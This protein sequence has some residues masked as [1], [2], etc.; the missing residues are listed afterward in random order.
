MNLDERQ[1]R[2]TLVDP[3]LWSSGWAEDQVERE[4]AYRPGK[5]RLLGEQ[6]VRDEPQ[7]VDYVLRDEP[8]GAI[9]AAVEA[10]DE[11]HAPGAGMQ[12]AL[13]YATDVLAP[14]AFATN[15]HE[16]VEQDMRTG[17]VRRLTEFP[18]PD[19]LLKRWQSDV[20]W[21]GQKVSGKR[22]G[23][24]S[25][26]LLQPAYSLPGAPSMRY[27]QERAVSAAIEQML[28]GHR[29][30]LLSL[31]TGTGKTFIAFNIVYKLLTSRYL[32][33]VLFIADRVNLR[34][35]AYNEFGGLGDRRGVVTGGQ[36][37]LERDVHFAIYQSLYAQSP[38]GPRV[39]ERYPRDYFDL[40]IVDE[41]HRSGY[42][43]W[44]AI[45]EHFDT[46]FHLGM[47]ATPK[48]D[49]S[50]NTYS[51]FASENP[52]DGGQPRPVYEYSLGRG[53]DDGFLATYKVLQVS[54]SVDEGL[55]INDEIERGAELLVP[56]GT[57]PRD[58]YEMR[59]FE[60][61]IIV[62]D[63]TRVLCEHLAGV[64]RT[65]G[66]LD[67]T[68]VFCVT[69]EHAELV[70]SEMQRLLGS[71]TG[72]NLYAARIVSE[73][74]DAQATLEQ[75]QLASSTE[76]VVVTTV[77]LLS[78]GVNAPSVRNIVFMKPIGSVTTFKQIIGRGSRIDGLTGKTFFRVIDYTN[79]TRLFDEWDLPSQ[80]AVTGPLTGNHAIAG[81]VQDEES[82]EPVAGASLSVRLQGRLLAET[83][84]AADGSFD[85]LDLPSAVLDVFIAASG[86]TRRHSRVDATSDDARNLVVALRRPSQGERRV[87]ISGLE[88]SIKDEIEVDLGNGHVLATSE[89][90]ARAKTVIRE[91]AG[92]F[93]EL[94]SA[95][96][97]RS[98]RDSLGEYLAMRQVTPELLG[99]VI[100]RTDVDAFDLLA[101]AAYDAPM[102]SRD[103]RATAAQGELE[104]KYPKLPDGLIV[105]VLDK[106]RLGGTAEVSSSEL[107]SL[108]P[109]S[110]AWGGVLGVASQL[111][112]P[113]QVAAFLQD[114]QICLFD[115]EIDG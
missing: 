115:T 21:R 8:R 102:T 16:I 14:F 59:A 41:C 60:R 83:R 81:Y 96:Q 23:E 110:A 38:A 5:L 58:V 54:T 105:A 79:A 9:L 1:T 30:A 31:A 92:S 73:E 69:M 6:T 25:N 101:A 114:V 24:A 36:V 82:A 40:V 61:D 46:A 49:D 93:D 37:P 35:Q 75:F 109:F 89:Y 106:F 19:E 3:L 51:F 94:R 64:L 111:G 112:G 72:K 43:D 80:P 99:L 53:I 84:S 45:L 108:L 42:G 68:M 56:E 48:E 113:E 91:R 87:R 28:I 12:Q 95:W 7:F 76:P 55:V 88:V 85:V 100:G 39:F 34:D 17:A 47:T 65:Y 44:G 70:R 13:A 57:T 98:E 90:L 52:D 86:Y 11:S 103:A 26:P 15:G 22:G 97:E 10:K 71:E 62:P 74:R 66:P 104:K 33:R 77:D 4:Y 32:K 29:R 63:R 18:S 20:T 50:I 107:F 67:K 2:A 27:Y 78:T